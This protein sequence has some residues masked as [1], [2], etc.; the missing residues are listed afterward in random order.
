MSFYKYLEQFTQKSKRSNSN[1]KNKTKLFNNRTNIS[2]EEKI[3]SVYKNHINTLS[4]VW[5]V[6]ADPLQNIVWLG[7]INFLHLSEHHLEL[8][9]KLA[10]LL[11]SLF[12]GVFWKSKSSLFHT[13]LQIQTEIDNKWHSLKKILDWRPLSKFMQNR[14][15]WSLLTLVFSCSETTLGDD[16]N[17][18]VFLLGSKE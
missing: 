18:N 10:L 9:R 17:Y 5:C 15:V 2:L 11:L 7:L 8:C 6:M 1:T 16:N 13:K 12:I 3:L 14:T 4:W